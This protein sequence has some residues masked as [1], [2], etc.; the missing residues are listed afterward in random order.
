MYLHRNTKKMNKSKNFEKAYPDEISE[1]N[2]LMFKD[3]DTDTWMYGKV[4]EKKTVEKETSSLKGAKIMSHTDT[5]ITV[6]TKYGPTTIME[7]NFF[8]KEQK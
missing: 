3:T 5:E 4:I 8:V 6:Q 2:M 1:G 7:T